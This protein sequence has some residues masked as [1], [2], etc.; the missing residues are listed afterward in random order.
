LKCQLKYIQKQAKYDIITIV[1]RGDFMEQ[2]Y[3]LENCKS[4]EPEHI[5]ECGQ[6]FRWN[7]QEDGSYT[8]IFKQ[9][10]VNVKKAD[11][12]IIFRGICK[13][14]IK[15][16]CI[17]YFDLNTNYDNIK[18]KLSNVDNYLKTSIEYGEGIRILNQ[19]LWE[20]L[21]S[22]II[23]ANN[24]IP[25]IKGIIERISKSYG[26]KIV[27]DKAEYY[28]FP[29]PQELSKASVEDLR[30]IGLGFRDVR[31][32]ETTKIINEN[33]N[34]L[35]ELEDEKDVN[36][37]R[38]ELL[39]F[40]GVG[41]KVADCVMLFST[42][43][44]LEVFPIDVWVRRVMN[45]LYIKNEDETKINKKEI[46][47]LAKTKYGNLAGIAQQYLFYWRRGA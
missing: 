47:E 30:N 7:K 22:F 1:K 18:S 12:K 31:V 9:N 37:L 28:T 17:K 4:F 42:L 32:Y 43:K 44:K 19:D 29:T 25:R 33:P 46:E 5:F 39:K 20:T 11:N 45:E 24:N 41:P 10:V 26:E 8:G 40:P 3:I 34:K 36:K 15:D 14:N 21:I 6:C 27:W 13:E 35:K 38:E 23:S 16:E 2:E